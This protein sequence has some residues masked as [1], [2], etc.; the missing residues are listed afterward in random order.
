[1]R[2]SVSMYLNQESVGNISLSSSDFL[3]CE[4]SNES[5]D[6]YVPCSLESFIY[7]SLSMYLRICRFTLL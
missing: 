7:R 1:M 4:I 6:I 5:T 2:Q 3:M